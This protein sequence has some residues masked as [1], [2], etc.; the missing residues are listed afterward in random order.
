MIGRARA[1]V[2]V[3]GDLFVFLIEG[4]ATG[5]GTRPTG[6]RARADAPLC[7]GSS[8]RLDPAFDVLRMPWDKVPVTEGCRATARAGSGAS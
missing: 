2:Q 4:G 7:G 8:V 1:V 3:A 5:R 6:R